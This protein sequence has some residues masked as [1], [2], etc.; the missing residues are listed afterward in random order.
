MLSD[1]EALS[2]RRELGEL[3]K[4]VCLDFL[5]KEDVDHIT[6]KRFCRLYDYYFPPKDPKE[7]EG[8]FFL[9][10]RVFIVAL[11]CNQFEDVRILIW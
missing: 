6:R 1:N 4:R 8:F 7:I 9:P 11:V 5:Y 3:Y 10:P 2:H